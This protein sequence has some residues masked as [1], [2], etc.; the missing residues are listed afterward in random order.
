MVMHMFGCTDP[1]NGKFQYSED[2]SGFNISSEI[3]PINKTIK[4][5][6][7]MS[8]VNGV[9][10]E[11]KVENNKPVLFREIIRSDGIDSTKLYKNEKVISIKVDTVQN[12]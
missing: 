10:W 11:Y 6:W 5:Y 9:T 1:N 4:E 8:A 2:F 7:H 12:E 3:D